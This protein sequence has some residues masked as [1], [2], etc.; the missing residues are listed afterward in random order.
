MVCSRVSSVAM[1]RTRGARM[2]KA[3]ERCELTMHTPHLACSCMSSASLRGAHPVSFLAHGQSLSGMR[4][5]GVHFRALCPCKGCD[6]C[7]PVCSPSRFTSALSPSPCIAAAM[8][9][10]FSTPSPLLSSSQ[11]SCAR[12][13]SLSRTNLLNSSNCRH[14]RR[15]LRG[16]CARTQRVNS[17]RDVQ[18][19]WPQQQQLAA[20]EHKRCT[21]T[22]TAAAQAASACSA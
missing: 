11:Y 14:L 16:Q 22:V 19:Q 10:L 1:M 20:Y 2:V 8:S 4:A 12:S 7:L 5:R 18:Q 15:W 13:R 3:C 9:S 21:V 6:C 17:T